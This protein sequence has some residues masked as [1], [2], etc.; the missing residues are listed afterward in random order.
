VLAVV[1]VVFA[2]ALTVP[3]AASAETFTVNSV[4]DAVDATVGNEFCETADAKCTLRA[5]IEEAN[6]SAEAFDAIG[7]DKGVFHGDADGI[8]ELTSALPPITAPLSLSGCESEAGVQGPCV[9]IDGIADEPGLEVKDA[10]E[11]EIERLAVTNSRVGIAAEGVP[12]L[13]LRGVW[14]GIG[15]GGV[16]GGNGSGIELGPGS[17]GSRIGVEDPELLSVI[18]NSAGPGLTILGSRGVQVLG[19]QFGVGPEGTQSAPNGINIAIASTAGNAD[20]VGNTIG[21]RVGAAAAASLACELGCNLISGAKSHGI[22]LSGGDFNS[23]AIETTIVGNHIGLDRAGTGSIPN[24]GAGILVGAAPKTVIGGPRGDDANRIVGGSAAVQAG[25]GA[26]YFVVQRN[27]IGSRATES[28]ALEPPEEGIAVD[29]QGLSLPAEEA[30]IVE[31]EIGL[32]GGIGI[33]NRGVGATIFRNRIAGAAEGIRVHGEGPGNLIE[34]NLVTASADAGILVENSSNNVIGNEVVGAGTGLRIAK[35]SA[36]VPM[37]NVVGGNSAATENVISKTGNAIEIIN[38]EESLTEVARNRGSGNTGLFI[39]LIPVASAGGP[40]KDILPPLIVVIS[41][42]GAAGFAEP[43]ATVRVFGKAT[44][45]PGEIQS[46][47]GAVTADEDGN[48]SLTF[49]TP[50]APGAAIAATQTKEE[51]TSELEIA[52]VAVTPAGQRAAVPNASAP[53]TVDLKPPRTRILRQPR[54]LPAGGVARFVFT[55][56]EPG[57]SFQCS[58]DRGKFRACTSP[59]KYRNLRPGKYVFRVYAAD[60]AGNIDR[61]PVRRRF[62]VLD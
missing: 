30:L 37:G 17:D 45:A 16:A 20:A 22:D 46:F 21:T 10:G 35:T 47:L 11:F 48:W 33:S 7:F 55:A 54:R 15:L 49:P 18:V 50:L 24:A 28:G 1:A 27:L 42:A 52:T 34:G 25:P 53:A 23:P 31:N 9:E 14:L 43:G 51:G 62:K 60:P 32:S 8:I 6:S 19:T 12:R 39:D 57:T 3:A 26:P 5:A 44:P 4:G 38:A 29:S 13:K 41:E 61:T 36:E 2:C 40:N 59:M 58:L 56:D